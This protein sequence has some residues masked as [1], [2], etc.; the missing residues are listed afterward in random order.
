VLR[1]GGEPFR[2]SDVEELARERGR[3]HHAPVGKRER[4]RLALE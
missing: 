2:R 1:E 3:R 4:K